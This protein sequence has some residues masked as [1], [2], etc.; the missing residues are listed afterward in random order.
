MRRRTAVAFLAGAVACAS[1]RVDFAA[2][3]R[4]TETDSYD[5]VLRRWTR[6]AKLYVGF[7][8]QLSLR[9]TLKTWDFQ[10]AM[11]RRYADRYKLTDAERQAL[12]EKER[13]R[14]REYFD[15]IVVV[16]TP[17]LRRN[18]LDSKTSAWRVRL[19]VNGAESLAEPVRLVS[20]GRDP[21][22]EAFFP[23]H[24]AFSK[25]YVASFRRP[26]G[27]VR[28]VA[29]TIAGPEGNATV[30]WSSAAN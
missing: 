26:H 17:E 16:H 8:A 14:T 1:Q 10:Q 25:T 2:P 12:H 20:A 5:A 9:A 11:V 21:V 15:F 23:L 7:D 30:S 3:D 22:V 13:A 28:D 19:K 6:D 18:D 27:E 24:S 4:A 29:L